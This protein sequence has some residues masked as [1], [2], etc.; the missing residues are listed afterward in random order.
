MIEGEAEILQSSTRP[1]VLHGRPGMTVKF[2]EPDEPSKIVIGEL[3]KARLALKP[4][5]PSVGPRPAT[6]PDSPR[7]VPPAPSGRIDATN[8]LAECVV[9]GDVSSLREMASLPRG[10]GGSVND[11]SASKFVV[12]DIP[13]IG[14]PRAKTPSTSPAGAK[15]APTVAPAPTPA[16]PPPSAAPAPTA[17]PTSGAEPAPTSSNAE[18]PTVTGTPPAASTRMTSLGIPVIQ[19]LPAKTESGRVS[20]ATTLGMPAIDRKPEPPRTDAA[21]PPSTEPAPAPAESNPHEEATAIG[22]APGKRATDPTIQATPILDT[23]PDDEATAIGVTPPKTTPASMPAATPEPARVEP[24]K[25]SELPKS[26]KATSIGFPALRTPFQTQPLGVVPPPSTPADASAD[27]PAKAARPPASAPRSKAPTTP[28]S[29]PR[30][31]TPVAPVPI[32]RPPAK[33]IAPSADEERTDLAV[34]PPVSGALEA[35][36]G[37]TVSPADSQATQPPSEQAPSQPTE[38]APEQPTEQRAQRSGGM[39]ASEILAAIPAGDW[40]MTPEESVPHPLPPE[41]KLAAPPSAESPP[42]TGDWTMSVDP[43]KG[44]SEPEKVEKPE[45]PPAT[46]GNPVVAVASDKPI[47]VVQWEDKPT[48]AGE[49]KIEIDS[50]LMA[51]TAMEEASTTPPPPAAESHRPPPPPLGPMP[52]KPPM[53][54]QPDTALPTPY[55]VSLA[56]GGTTVSASAQRKKMI[57][58]AI[59]AGAIAI[60]AIVILVLTL[61]GD[62]KAPAAS[63]GTKTV[64]PPPAPEVPAPPAPT[65]SSAQTAVEPDGP[66]ETVPEPAVAATPAPNGACTVL[67]SS[68]PSGAQVYVDNQML[69]TTPGEIQLPCGTKANL[70]LR[71]ARYTTTT[72]AFTPEADKANKLFVRLERQQFSVKVTSSPAGATIKAGNKTLGVTPTTIKLPAHDVSTLTLSKPGY[73]T[74][75]SRITPRRNNTSHHVTLKKGRR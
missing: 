14:G 5:P 42:P 45:R 54:G 28:P 29:G 46:S 6:I 53:F 22:G 66:D 56:Y 65:P 16:A 17:T 51:A 69:G 62:K 37:E 57:A 30:H 38:Q 20:N 9:I 47:E 19:R 12:P 13:A 26:Y 39:R 48:S 2:I 32:V 25:R 1:T 49:S 72:R 21:A 36:T 33:T 15:P 50:E 70:S 44:W 43:N 74:T 24:P 64:E 35:V 73:A 23:A 59:G 41:A 67:V 3:E 10:L 75:R 71:R 63:T 11:R 31:P 58:M 4:A 68:A 60:A 55:P 52:P 27:S 61:S 7:P 40:T 8:A 18:A 34:A